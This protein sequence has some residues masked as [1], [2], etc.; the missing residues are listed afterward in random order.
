MLNKVTR[1]SLFS[2]YVVLWKI[3]VYLSVLRSSR[4][5]LGVLRAILWSRAVF[6]GFFKTFFC[7][8]L[9]CLWTLFT[10]LNPRIHNNCY[11]YDVNLKENCG[12]VLKMFIWFFFDTS[13]VSFIRAEF[14]LLDLM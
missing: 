10:D 1:V 6:C 8:I 13:Y 14:L 4:D 12:I 5:F 3:R 7:L 2:K 11:L 9:R